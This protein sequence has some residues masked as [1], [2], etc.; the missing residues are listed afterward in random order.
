[1]TKQTREFIAWWKSLTP[2]ER[3][4]EYE[5]MKARRAY[6]V[7]RRLRAVFGLKEEHHE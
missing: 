7:R 2:E 6:W 4:R 1:M 5:K 3:Q